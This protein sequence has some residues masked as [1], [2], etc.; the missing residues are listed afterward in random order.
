M[1]KKN[2]ENA[3]SFET[4][5]QVQNRMGKTVFS[6]EGNIQQEQQK[7]SDLN[8]RVLKICQKDPFL[9]TDSRQPFFLFIR[10]GA[11]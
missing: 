6:S 11:I 7:N 10:L 1:L 2:F 5:E 3:Q 8:K 9:S 4:F